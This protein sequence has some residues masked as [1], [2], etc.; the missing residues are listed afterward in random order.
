MPTFRRYLSSAKQSKKNARSLK[1]G[2]ICSPE[3][4][5]SNHLTL[6]NNP[7]DGRLQSFVSVFLFYVWR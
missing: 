3:T 4:L 1:M 2:P 7:N 5:A 6:R